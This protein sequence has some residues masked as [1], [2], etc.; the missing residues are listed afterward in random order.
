MSLVFFKPKSYNVIALLMV[1]VH[2]EV[3][4]NVYTKF[5][6]NSSNSCEDISLKPTKYNRK[7]K[8]ILGGPTDRMTL[9]ILKLCY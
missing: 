9:H 4:M 7:N 6:G 5:H 2:H 3:H 8:G 1:L